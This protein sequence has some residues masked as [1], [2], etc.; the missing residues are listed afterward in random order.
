MNTMAHDEISKAD[1]GAQGNNL[2]P[3]DH[4]FCP[5]A[6]HDVQP[7]DVVQ[8]DDSEYVA[9]QEPKPTNADSVWAG[10]EEPGWIS[11]GAMCR[12]I[13]RANPQPALAPDTTN[14]DRKPLRDMT[15]AE[16]GALVRA[17]NEGQVIEC[18]Y[19]GECSAWVSCDPE[20]C[21][22]DIYR[23]RPPEPKRETVKCHWGSW[24]FT[25]GHSSSDRDTHVITFDTIDGQPDCASIRME[26]LA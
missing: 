10:T 7:G 11:G 19:D 16:I 23:T 2:R 3:T 15:D 24:G 14:P 20:W 12:V 22:D 18:F 8:W 4:E 26:P 21:P 6:K 13:S 17:K 9:L 1:T 25:L 5:L